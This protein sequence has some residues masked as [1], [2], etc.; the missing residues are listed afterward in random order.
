MFINPV[1]TVL[2]IAALFVQAK[3]TKSRSDPGGLS[4]TGLAVQAVIFAVVAL[5]WL[6]RLVFPWN[7]HLINLGGLL[8]WYQYV[9]WVAVDN[10]I[11][12]VA[13]A[14][15]YWLATRSRRGIAGIGGGETEPL[16]HQ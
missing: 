11:F 1:V 4:V 9:G 7:E 6:F 15:L 14:V 8:M 12:A 2:C 13:Q 3:E 10:A 16:L 5:S